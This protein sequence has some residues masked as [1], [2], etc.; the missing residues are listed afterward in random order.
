MPVAVGFN[1]RFAPATELLLKAFQAAG[2][3]VS[4]FYRIS[5]DDRI[6]PP[7]QQWKKEDRL[8][9]EV[10]HIFD[11]LTYLDRRGADRRSTPARAGPTTP[12]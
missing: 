1:R 3:P 2:P 4:V 11:L 10:V 5:D 9:I 6:R 8:L 7:E 12:W